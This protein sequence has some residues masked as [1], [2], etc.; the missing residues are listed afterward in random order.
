[1][2]NPERN[3]P[4]GIVLAVIVATLLYMGVSITAVSVVPYAQL[5]DTQMHGAPLAQISAKAA[6]W[7]PGWV[8]TGITIFAV[9][10]TSLLNYVMGSRLVYGMSQQGLLPRAVGKV[11]PWRRTP[12]VA[13]G[14][15]MVI[16]IVLALVG[17]ISVLAQ[18]TSLLLLTVFTV[19]NAALVVLKFRQGEPPGR[20]EVPWVVPFLGALVCGGLIAFRLATP[21]K[22]RQ[23]AVVAGGLVAVAM[24]LYLI[25]RPRVSLRSSTELG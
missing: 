24:I 14:V 2:K 5:A 19:V 7:L 16:A 11:H 22:D 17:D 3:M 6:P 23:A 13:I 12:H 25:V 4:W 20:F 1:V 9:A 10:N 18:S 8:Y 15:L 21:G